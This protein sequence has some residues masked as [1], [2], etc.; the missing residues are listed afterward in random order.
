[1]PVR[2]FYKSTFIS[3]FAVVFF[4]IS[5]FFTHPDVIGLNSDALYLPALY[6]DLFIRGYHFSSWHLTPAPYFFPDMLL[7]FSIQV[8]VHNV[9]YSLLTF[10]I[11]QNIIILFL[12]SKIAFLATKNRASVFLTHIVFL[13]AL[14]S[15]DLSHL[16]IY[17]YL[18]KSA[19]HVGTLINGLLLILLLLTYEKYS[20]NLILLMMFIIAGLGAA[21]DAIFLIQIIL[22]LIFSFLLCKMFS[23][24]IGF[25]KSTFIFALAGGGVLGYFASHLFGAHTQYHYFLKKEINAFEVYYQIYHIFLNAFLINPL[26]GFASVFFYSLLLVKVFSRCLSY[27]KDYFSLNLSGQLCFLFLFILISVLFTCESMSINGILSPRYLLNIFWFPIFFIGILFPRIKM[28]KIL[29]F[30]LYL[31]ALFIIID[32]ASQYRTYQFSYTPSIVS[33][34]DHHIHEYNATHYDKIKYGISTYWQAKLVTVFSR[35]GLIISQLGSNTKPRLW[36]TSAEN[37]RKAYDFAILSKKDLLDLASIQRMSEGPVLSFRCSDD[38]D[39]LIYG[40]SRLRLP[41]N[42]STT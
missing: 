30:S 20:K 14:I 40:Q 38:I 4:T 15:C 27:K 24:K 37:Y 1:M 21:S 41:N 25:L 29:G 11:L 35:E 2:F 39:L 9:F 18:M 7:F 3:Y 34:I 26:M 31:V 32:K 13:L 12:I 17:T 22:P 36:I 23:I 6:L 16:E 5:V 28:E 42:E 10:A 8:L 19:F 33:C